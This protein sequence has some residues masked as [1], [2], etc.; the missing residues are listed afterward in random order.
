MEKSYDLMV[1]SK[2][3]RGVT[4]GTRYQ[5]IHRLHLHFW[6]LFLPQCISLDTPPSHPLR[7]PRSTP[8]LHPHPSTIIHPLYPSQEHHSG[9]PGSAKGPATWSPLAHSHTIHTIH[10]VPP[11]H[12]PCA[13]TCPSEIGTRFSPDWTSCPFPC[14]I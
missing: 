10:H 5:F 8:N 9:L 13:C 3:I 4:L 11:T 6:Y 1:I 7:F 14:S 2:N 12:T